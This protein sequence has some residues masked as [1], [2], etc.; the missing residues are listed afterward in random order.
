MPGGVGKV[1]ALD[2]EQ[3]SESHAVEEN[4]GEKLDLLLSLTEKDASLAPLIPILIEAQKAAEKG[5]KFSHE[6]VERVADLVRN[7]PGM[8]SIDDAIARARVFEDRTKPNMFARAVLLEL[9]RRKDV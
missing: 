7:L 2:P 4:L 6:D 1:H 3:S 9:Q 8:A 5:P